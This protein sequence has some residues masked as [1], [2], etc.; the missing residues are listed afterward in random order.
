MPLTT[1]YGDGNGTRVI[2]D[3][4]IIPQTI[5]PQ[6]LSYINRLSAS[7][8]IPSRN[9]IDAVNNLIWSMVTLGIYAKCD[10]I[11]P[12][13]GNSTATVGF[14]LKNTFNATFSGSW[15]VTSTGMRPTTAN[16]A[17]RA[18]TT[19]NPNT[20]GNGTNDHLSIYLRTNQTAAN[21]PIGCFDGNNLFQINGS[22]TGN[23]IINNTVSGIMSV[24]LASSTGFWIASRI[25]ATNSRLYINGVVQGS[26]SN[27]SPTRPNLPVSLGVR[28]TSGPNY[29][30]P[31]SS[32]IALVSIG[33]G[34][35]QD[36]VRHF[37][38]LVQAYQL[39]LGRQI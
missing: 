7:G 29:D 10:L 28:T 13:I 1:I 20:N 39:K 24:T 5:H 21:V 19:W 35:T 34:L 25:S 23:A 30:F 9:E 14:D 3:S 26:T 31:S 32:E 38:I 18:N 16:I 6:V 37:N 17:N 22:T 11:Y 4:T 27:N 2:G 36:E 12:V 8:Y 15:T 33:D